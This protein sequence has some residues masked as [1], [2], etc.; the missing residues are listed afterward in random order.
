MPDLLQHVLV[1]I[2]AAGAAVVL[3]RRVAGIV[4]S[5]RRESTPCAN[6]PSASQHH[7]ESAPAASPAVKPLTLVRR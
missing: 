7:R 1:T 2:V 6:C 3:L 5:P 4:R